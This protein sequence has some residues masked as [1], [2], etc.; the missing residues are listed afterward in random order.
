MKLIIEGIV[1]IIILALVV[2]TLLEM[3]RPYAPWLMLGGVGFLVSRYLLHRYRR[4]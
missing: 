1:T 2:S 4:Y 3:V